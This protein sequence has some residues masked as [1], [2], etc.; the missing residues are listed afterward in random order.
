MARNYPLV[1]SVTQRPYD[2]SLLRGIQAADPENLLEIVAAAIRLE[3]ALYEN[4]D[5]ERFLFRLRK[6]L[7]GVW[8]HEIPVTDE[9]GH[10]REE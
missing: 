7:E 2:E 5:H 1:S 6:A 8:G 10:T 4:V 9:W 3:C